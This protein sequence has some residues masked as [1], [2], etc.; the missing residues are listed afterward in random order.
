M[1][2]R[3]KEI[4]EKKLLTDDFTKYTFRD[5]KLCEYCSFTKYEVSIKFCIIEQCKNIILKEEYKKVKD[6]IDTEYIR[7]LDRMKPYDIAKIHQRDFKETEDKGNEDK[8]KEE[9]K[10]IEKDEN[11]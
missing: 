9:L 10:K 3:I 6:L 11:P 1:L 4:T 7:K 5:K 8:L 2:N